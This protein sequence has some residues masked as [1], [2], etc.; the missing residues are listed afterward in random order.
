M[1]GKVVAALVAAI[2]VGLVLVAGILLAG[3]GEEQAAAERPATTAAAGPRPASG[4]VAPALAGTDPI[5]GRTV[6]LADFRGKSVVI[7]VWA[8]WC[9][10]CTDEAPELAR[11]A[12]LHPEA[13]LLGIDLQ[14][15]AAGAKRFYR[16]Y[17]WRHP[18]IFDPEGELA[19]RLGLVGLPT[20][21]FLTPEHRESSRVA[22]PVSLAQ[23]EEGLAAAAGG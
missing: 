12:E 22:G 2:G 8:S 5:T 4:P 21:I 13:V 14:D 6:R 1:R 23:L 9:G 16:R 18:S 15:T 17:G 10:P 3:D 7:N 20:T 19:A 11:F